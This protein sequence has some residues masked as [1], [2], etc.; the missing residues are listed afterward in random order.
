MRW[1]R[2]KL[3]VKCPDGW[4]KRNKVFKAQRAQQRSLLKLKRCS[5]RVCSYKPK[6]PFAS[7]D[8]CRR[9]RALTFSLLKARAGAQCFSI[10]HVEH[11]VPSCLTISHHRHRHDSC[12]PVWPIPLHL[13]HEPE[14]TN[15]TKKKQ[16]T[17]P[18][19][20]FHWKEKVE[21]TSIN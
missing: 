8:I 18:P 1:R 5:R 6:S 16:N 3:Q 12:V 10:W 2:G 11:S 7:L 15:K 9:I 21:A 4:Q 19:L 20:W 17:E 14:P 13:F